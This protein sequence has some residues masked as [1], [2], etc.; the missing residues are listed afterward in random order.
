MNPSG[1]VGS[2]TVNS[3]NES[4]SMSFSALSNSSQCT[5]HEME[6]MKTL[7]QSFREH[8]E[9]MEQHLIGQQALLSR[10]MSE[11]ER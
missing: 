3:Y 8:L 11:E 9:E 6:A 7:C 2:T 10:D 5:V 1:M 4:R